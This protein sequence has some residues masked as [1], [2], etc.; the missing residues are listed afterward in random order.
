MGTEHTGR[1]VSIAQGNDGPGE[2]DRLEPI[3]VLGLVTLDGQGGVFGF[4]QHHGVSGTLEGAV[5]AVTVAAFGGVVDEEDGRTGL[6]LHRVG[7]VDGD[8]DVFGAVLVAADDRAG[9]GVKDDEGRVEALG[10]FDE[11]DAAF[12]LEEA[13]GAGVEVDGV[14]F[15]DVEG[16]GPGAEP[17]AHPADAFGGDVEDGAAADFSS[18]PGH[19]GGDA[20]RPVE[21]E[22]ALAAAGFAV[23]HGERGG[24]KDVVDEPSGWRHGDDLSCGQ[25]LGVEAINES[26]GGGWDVAGVGWGVDGAGGGSGGGG[27]G[28]GGGVWLAGGGGGGGWWEGGGGGSGRSP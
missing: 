10:E 9:E 22:E 14:G 1:K 3:G 24:G 7:G 17:D 2:L 20:Q 28:G 26:F 27:G 11:A 12:S 4:D 19:A 6:G 13:D 18:V 15:G 5:A 25:E 23:E 21:R 8:A 16:L